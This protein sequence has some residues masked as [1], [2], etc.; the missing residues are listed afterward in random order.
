MELNLVVEKLIVY[1]KHHLF[2]K[3]LNQ[4]YFRNIL[5]HRF[6]LK[7][8]SNLDIDEEEISKM[9]TPDLLINELE[10]CLL[11]QGIESNE[12]NNI[13]IEL[14]GL[15]TPSPDE[16]NE[17]FNLLMKE[18]SKKALD[19]LYQLQIKNDYIKK[20]AIEK[21]IYWKK[22]FDSHF[23]EITINLSKPEKDNKSI[24][25]LIKIKNQNDYP[26]CLLCKENLG[27]H[28]SINHPARENIRIIPLKLNNES[29]FMQYSP[30][31]YYNHHC[32]IINNEHIPMH[33]EEA[34]FHRFVDFL[35]MFPSYF[36]GS[37]ADLPI[38]GGSILNHEHYQGGGHK[39][40]MMSSNNRFLIYDQ[41][42]L[43]I[44]YLDWYN[45]VVKIESSKANQVIKVMNKIKLEWSNYN[46]N[47]LSICAFENGI[48]HNTITP[49]MVKENNKYIAY[50]I[51]R[52]N[53]TSQEFPDGIFHAHQEYHNI[54]KEGIGLIEAMGLFILP[55]RLKSECEIIEEVLLN[56]CSL[57]ETI[58]LH[59]EINKYLSM[60][61]FLSS[62]KL[63]NRL[64][65]KQV[66]KDYIA[67]ICKNILINT[68]VFK[69]NEQGNKAAKEFIF[70][71][72]KDLDYGY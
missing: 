3:E 19:Y 30:Y 60:I 46:N 55:P 2:L 51:L 5:H 24:A 59:P 70:S 61:E 53:C 56:N 29:W 42:G 41:N 52:N 26:K 4:V 14:M 35:D 11:E 49:I 69:N 22:E 8:K 32:I 10:A 23:L 33:I 27:L 66:I 36:I 31:A 7:M 65:V 71:A 67:D 28:G 62:N 16:V 58:K 57:D 21:N 50:I 45:S 6:N 38:V 34:T 43:S 64:Q 44:S 68:A 15:L 9:E 12:V 1:A 40:P 18:S 17:H 54:K 37:N 72:I 13:S 48:R 25:K 20:T 63:E 39:M 47:K